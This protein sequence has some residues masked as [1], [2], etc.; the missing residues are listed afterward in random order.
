M[1]FLFIS[2]FILPLA[3]DMLMSLGVWPSLTRACS[4]WAASR[5]SL[6]A[7][8]E[9]SLKARVLDDAWSRISFTAF[10]TPVLPHGYQDVVFGRGPRARSP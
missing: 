9:D 5:A 3:A 10:S 6:A 4:T 7:W 8:I 1:T 2:I